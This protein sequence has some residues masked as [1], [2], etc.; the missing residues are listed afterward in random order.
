LNPVISNAFLVHLFTELLAID[1][2]YVPAFNKAFSVGSKLTC[3][4]NKAANGTLGCHR[5]VKFSHNGHA[6]FDGSPV[7]TLNQ[8]FLGVLFQYK[9]YTTVGP[10]PAALFYL[11]ALLSEDGAN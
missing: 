7:L 5:A 11:K 9:I 10:L 4:G 2:P 8:I 6:D 1:K 3:G